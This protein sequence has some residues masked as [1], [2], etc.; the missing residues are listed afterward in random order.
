MIVDRTNNSGLKIYVCV[1][2]RARVCGSKKGR[3]GREREREV[4]KT[5]LMNGVA[6]GNASR[7]PSERKS[8]EKNRLRGRFLQTLI[9]NLNRA[10]HTPR[11]SR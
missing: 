11:Q 5:V 9:I 3:E 4:R 1:Y 2:A 10:V 6:R 8:R 7:F